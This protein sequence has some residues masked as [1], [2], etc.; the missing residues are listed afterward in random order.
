MLL[1]DVNR[2]EADRKAAASK[3]WRKL[4]PDDAR[5][6]VMIAQA[7]DLFRQANLADDAIALYNRAIKLA[8]DAS[9][10]REYL[11]EYYHALKRPD[12][13][14]R[15]W[16]STV[17]GSSRNARSLGRLG[18]VLAGFGYRKEALEPLTEACRLEPDDFDLRL[19]LADLKLAM[20][21]PTEALVELEKASKSAT[22]DEQTEAVLDRQIRAYQASNTLGAQIDGLRLELV[23]TPNALGWTRLARLL[24]ADQKPPEAVQAIEQA[25]KID[26]RSVPAWVANARLREA[27]GDLLGSSNALRTLTTLDRRSRTDYLTG[28]RQ[29]REPSRPSRTRARSRSRTPRRRARQP[30]PPPV[31]CRAMLQPGRGRRGSRRPATSRQGQPLR[32]QGHAHPGRKPEPPVPHRGGHRALLASFCADE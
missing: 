1:R 31:F 27:A 23:K 4:A 28:N 8:P 20:E 21:Q 19:R 11:G 10:Y 15:T 5:D 9:Q 24:E 26:P 30:R 12:D 2:P 16:R 22:A 25:T 17:E 7:A 29:A 14:L 13:A 32:P 18:E 6:A 3:V